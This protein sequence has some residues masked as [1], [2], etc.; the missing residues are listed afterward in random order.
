MLVPRSSGNGV[1]PIGVGDDG[2]SYNINADL[3]AGKDPGLPDETLLFPGHL[4]APE[5]S[6]TMGEQKRTNPYLR[7]VDVPAFVEAAHARDVK[8]IIDSTFWK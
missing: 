4:Y 2:H 1:A 6:S 8:V 7:V 3:V 5:P